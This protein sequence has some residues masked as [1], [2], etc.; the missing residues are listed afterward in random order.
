MCLAAEHLTDYERLT[1]A[2]ALEP[3]SF[4]DQDVCPC[5]CAAPVCA[6][7]GLG[8]GDWALGW[9][10]IPSLH[11]PPPHRDP[12]PMTE[13]QTGGHYSGSGGS[14]LMV[15]SRSHRRREQPHLRALLPP[16]PPKHNTPSAGFRG[17]ALPTRPCPR[18]TGPH[19]TVAFPQ[20]ANCRL[21]HPPNFTIL[22]KTSCE[23]S[24]APVW[25]GRRG[26]EAAPD[27]VPQSH[28]HEGCAY[29]HVYAHV[30]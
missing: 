26:A 20:N 1:I 4:K 27:T 14:L 17:S 13:L 22:V 15:R 19:H 21:E 29:A 6:S 11:P 9:S 10:L 25:E 7:L 28:S 12:P 24:P 5:P 23:A 30:C 8:A 18:V 16:F 3:C 2:D